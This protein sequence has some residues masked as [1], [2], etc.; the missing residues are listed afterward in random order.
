M[1]LPDEREGDVLAMLDTARVAEESIGDLFAKYGPATVQECI[2]A[3]MDR[4]EQGM[5]ERIAML[6]DGEYYYEHYMDNS[7]LTPEP[8]PL[9]AKLTIEGDTMSFDFTGSAAQVVGPMN[10]GVPV[11]RGAAFVV[12][13]SWLDPK[14]PVNGGTFRPLSFIVPEGSCLAGELPGRPAAGPSRRMLGRVPPA[15]DR[16][17]RPVL[18]VLAQ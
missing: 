11:T 10:C 16:G 18:S 6:P 3:L 1:R 12:V 9:K 17:H 7:G 2:K 14:S 15:P 4:A 8:L 5:R 13:K